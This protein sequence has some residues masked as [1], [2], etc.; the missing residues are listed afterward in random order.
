MQSTAK[1]G[2]LLVVFVGLLIGG[3]AVLGKSLFAP[4]SDAYYVKLTDAAGVTEGTQVVISGVQVGTV[5]RVRL[6]NPTM[7]ELK[8]A[9]VKGTQIPEGSQVKLPTSLIGFGD[10][11]VTI[12][13]STA[14][15]TFLRPGATLQG[16]KGSPLDSFLP[17]GRQTV[18]EL[19]KT[20][21]AFRKL[22]EDQKLQSKVGD[23][24]V[25]T[26]KTLEHFG[27]LAGNISALLQKNQGNIGKQLLPPPRRLRMSTRSR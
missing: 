13:P 6:L 5:S 12:V 2:L 14:T 15:N 25:T 8:L 19:N 9:L 20:M 16:Y 10:T 7:A 4:S 22:L 18:V 11:P 21:V 3:Y 24:L 26:N 1:V 23:L 17:E 27:T